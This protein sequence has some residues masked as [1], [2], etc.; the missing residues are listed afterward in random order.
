MTSDG[1]GVSDLEKEE[2]RE[3]EEDDIVESMAFSNP[4][5]GGCGGTL[6]PCPVVEEYAK[7]RP[8]VGVS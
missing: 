1:V 2:D 3:E 5:E 4:V 8:G 6:R 7:A